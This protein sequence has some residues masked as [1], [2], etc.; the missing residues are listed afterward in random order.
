M[1]FSL[2]F[3]FVESP[4]SL[5]NHQSPSKDGLEKLSV[6]EG[7]MFP[8]DISLTNAGGYR[9]APY[10]KNRVILFIFLPFAIYYGSAVRR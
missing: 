3:S 9:R 6:P 5:H 8:A 4:L 2:P 1:K 7:S 10:R